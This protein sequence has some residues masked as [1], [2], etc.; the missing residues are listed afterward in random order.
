[1]NVVLLDIINKHVLKLDDAR[2][3]NRNSNNNNNNS[4]VTIDGEKASEQVSEA[5]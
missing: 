3:K 1:M 5:E 4:S 2:N